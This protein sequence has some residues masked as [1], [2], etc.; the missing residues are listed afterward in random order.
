MATDF[1]Q[2]SVLFFLQSSGGSVKNSELLVHFRAFLQDAQNRDRNRELFKKF[3]NSVAIVKQV[4]GA[5]HV[6]LRKKFRGHVSGAGRDSPG[7]AGNY[8]EPSASAEPEG[9]LLPPPGETRREAVLQAAGIVGKNQRNEERKTTQKPKYISPEPAIRQVQLGG[10]QV[11]VSPDPVTR[12]VQVW[13]QQQVKVSP[14][15]VVRQVQLGGQQ[16][17]NIRNISPEPV[18]RQV[19]MGGPQQEKVSPDPVIRQVQMG[20]PQQLKISSDPVI[21]QAQTGGQQQV[22]VSPEPLIRPVQIGGLSGHPGPDQNPRLGLPTLGLQ[23]PGPPKGLV[24]GRRFRY[25]PSYRSAVSQDD[26][27]DEVPVRPGP[28]LGSVD[29]EK[30]LPSSPCIPESQSSSSSGRT[31]SLMEEEIPVPPDLLEVQRQEAGSV[32]METS[33]LVSSLG[34]GRRLKHS[35]SYKTAVSQEEEEDDEVEAPVKPGPGGGPWP[36]SP[37]GRTISGSSE[38]AESC[39][40]SSG[41]PVPHIFI[42]DTEDQPGSVAVEMTR[43]ESDPAGPDQNQTRSC[44]PSSVLRPSDRF[45]SG[46]SRTPGRISSEENRGTKQP[47]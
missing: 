12:Q 40:S 15:P 28:G 2:D 43:P 7:S 44:S 45:Y 24:P 37:P 1:T 47:A 22:S 26:D 35:P 27:D 23:E 11:K 9:S 19:Q 8:T 14:D 17:V 41:R 18:T 16:Q 4:D 25:R 6:L 13:G 32:P 10:P 31:Q 42:Q 5:S 20:G 39:S 29:S 46:S 3:V 21:R 30:T 36:Q 38:S 34:P 33:E